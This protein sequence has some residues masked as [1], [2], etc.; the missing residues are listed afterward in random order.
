MISSFASDSVFRKKTKNFDN[1]YVT[2]TEK[3]S[4][5]MNKVNTLY[6]IWYN[7]EKSYECH[8]ILEST[9]AISMLSS[10]I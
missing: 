9:T 2:S 3:T 4:S 10:H 5:Y 1:D 7:M 8:T 6:S